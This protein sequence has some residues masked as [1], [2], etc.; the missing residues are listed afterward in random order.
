MRDVAEFASGAKVK[1]SRRDAGGRAECAR[2]IGCGSLASSGCDFFCGSNLRAI[3]SRRRGANDEWP[4]KVFNRTVENRVEKLCCESKTEEN[5]GLMH[6]AQVVC[7]FHC[8][9]KILARG[10]LI[11]A[12]N[13]NEPAVRVLFR[14]SLLRSLSR[15]TCH[16]SS[17]P[18]RPLE[19]GFCREECR[20][21]SPSRPRSFSNSVR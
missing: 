12:F 17:N 4:V 21:P 9:Q 3:R 1:I 7:S 10:V 13:T 14:G 19:L 11:P 20:E 18:L 2:R 5:V 8:S 6:F 15:T 16:T